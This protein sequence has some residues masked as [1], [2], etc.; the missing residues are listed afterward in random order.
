[1]SRCKDKTAASRTARAGHT[2]ILKAKLTTVCDFFHMKMLNDLDSWSKTDRYFQQH[3]LKYVLAGFS[4]CLSCCGLIPQ[5][6]VKLALMLL[7][8]TTDHL[9]SAGLTLL[10]IQNLKAL[11]L[12][13]L[14]LKISCSLEN[15]GYSW[16]LTL[17]CVWSVSITVSG[18][19]GTYR[20]YGSMLSISTS[21]C[22]YHC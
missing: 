6:K 19:T 17:K 13:T 9:K 5:R 20:S 18:E 7:N 8:G 10:V 3:S 12:L 14:L 21:F 11:N 4:S 2:I 15:G 1:M 16:F 22:K